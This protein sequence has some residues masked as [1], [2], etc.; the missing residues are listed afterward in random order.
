MPEHARALSK[1]ECQDLYNEIISQ[2]QDAEPSKARKTKLT[3]DSLISKQVVVNAEQPNTQAPKA[4]EQKVFSLR[5]FVFSVLNQSPLTVKEKLDL[6]YDI[7]S[8]SSKSVDGI[9]MHEAHLI[10]ETILR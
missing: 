1:S 5:S 7:T 2:K 10:Y 8:Y 3:L 6:L 4:Q 9:D